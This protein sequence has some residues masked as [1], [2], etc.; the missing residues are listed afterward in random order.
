M[1]TDPTLNVLIILN[2]SFFPVQFNSILQH[3]SIVLESLPVNKPFHVVG[4]SIIFKVSRF[5]SDRDAPGQANPTLPHS[6]SNVA[7]S[8]DTRVEERKQCTS[9]FAQGVGR[10]FGIAWLLTG[11]SA[12]VLVNYFLFYTAKNLFFSRGRRDQ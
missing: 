9:T 2:D 1:Y 10:G 12:S 4:S 5:F 8:L 7:K 6:L 11:T 3:L